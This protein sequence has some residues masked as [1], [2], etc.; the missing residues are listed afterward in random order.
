MEFGSSDLFCQSFMVFSGNDFIATDGVAEG[1]PLIFGED[2]LVDDYYTLQPD[3]LPNRLSIAQNAGAALV[4]GPDSGTGTAGNTVHV[5]SHLLLIDRLG[6]TLEALLLV[7]EL[8]GLAVA[9]HLLPLGALQPKVEYRLSGIRQQGTRHRLAQ[10][11]LL[12]FPLGTRVA[13]A[14]NILRTVEDIKTGDRILAE[15]GRKMT[16]HW[17]G[18]TPLLS[19]R[20]MAPVMVDAGRFGNEKALLLSPRHRVLGQLLRNKM[21]QDGIRQIEPKLMTY[22]Q[23]V[24]VD[25]QAVRIDGASADCLFIGHPARSAANAQHPVP[26]QAAAQHNWR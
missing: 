8:G 9:I 7:E 5:D 10:V 11:P 20:A 19:S 3:A 22:V 2:L 15:D 24:V 6:N 16:V 21:G 4:V 26:Q 23:M 18:A 14:D 25:P 17:V 1:D 12:Q 13:T